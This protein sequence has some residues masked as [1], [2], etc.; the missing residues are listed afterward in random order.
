M[1]TLVE[2]R[3]MNNFVS[4]QDVKYLHCKPKNCTGMCKVF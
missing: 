4:E 1:E 3:E 2:T